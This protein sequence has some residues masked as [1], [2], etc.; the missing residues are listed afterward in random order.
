MNRSLENKLIVVTGG[1]SG[2]GAAICEKV[3]LHGAKVAILDWNEAAALNFQN[4]LRNKGA[5]AK[6]YKVDVSDPLNVKSTFSYIVDDL[7]TPDGL[8]NNAGISHV[9][10][11]ETTHIDDMNRLYAINVLGVFNTLQAG[12][13]LMKQKGGSIVNMASVL[14]TRGVPDRF[15]YSMCKGA[16]ISMTLSVAADMIAHG[17]R[18]NCVS[19]ARVHTPFVDDY[20]AKNYPGNE[21]QMFETLAK[22]APMKRMGKPEEVADLVTFLLSD[23]ASFM[24]GYDYAVDGGFLNLKVS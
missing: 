9:G 3:V 16:V 2:I 1:A 5:E 20:L 21:K 13:E 12:V 22:T 17:I 19:P 15:A 6:A 4:S 23:G 24:T 11:I 8:V 10:T 18:C 14:G 7:G